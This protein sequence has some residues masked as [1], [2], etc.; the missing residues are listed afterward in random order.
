MYPDQIPALLTTLESEAADIAIAKFTAAAPVS[1]L[2]AQ[3]EWIDAC[4]SAD[5]VAEIVARLQA[6]DSPEANKA[7]ADVLGKSPVALQVTLRSL[8]SAKGTGSL[9]AVLNEEYRVSIASLASH[10]LVE[11]IRAQVVDKDRAPRW[12]AASVRDISRAEVLAAFGE[13]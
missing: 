6:D 9:E 5:T 2:A 8:R 3:R 13:S 1:A 4:Y 12:T 7:A 10:D 11:G